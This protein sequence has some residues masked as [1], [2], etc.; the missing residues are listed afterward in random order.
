[1]SAEEITNDAV[2]RVG[3][4]TEKLTR[5]NMKEAVCEHIQALCRKDSTFARRTM[6][7]EKSMINCF[8]YIY[9]MARE[10]AEQEMKDNGIARTGTY[11]CDVPNGL[12]FQ[13]AEDY[14][15]ADDVKEDHKDDE[16]F[17]PKPY[18]PATR[19]KAQ[20]KTDKKPSGTAKS[21]AG[22]ASAAPGDS[23]EQIS[24]M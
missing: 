11:G 2:K 7:P 16:K 19:K 10:Y 20:G 6:L 17:V 21:R 5:R 24:L 14:F 13:W 3:A 8:Q 18:I 9:R 4:D 15:N 12:C 23:M 1:M 22:K